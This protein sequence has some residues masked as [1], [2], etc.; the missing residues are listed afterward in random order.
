M[1]TK[2]RFSDTFF[3]RQLMRWNANFN[4]REM[5]WKG[6]SDPY[7]IWLSEIILQQ[8]QVAQG[9]SYYHKFIQTYPTVSHL[10]NADPNDVFKLWEGL[11]YYSRCKNLL[12]AANQIVTNFNCRFPDTYNDILSLKGI[13]PYTAAAIASFAFKLPY[14][15]VDG[16]VIRVLSRYFAISTPYDTTEGKKIFQE[17]ANELLDT[18][19]PHL[20]NQAIMDFGAT[21]CT[22]ANPACIQCILSKH[23]ASNLKNNVLDFPVKSKKI[24]K[25]KRFFIF[26]IIENNK[27]QILVKKREQN[28]IWQNLHQFFEI[29]NESLFLA[30]ND[31]LF[32]TLK[33]QFP[34]LQFS[35]QL[36]VF[37]EQKQTLTHQT[38]YSKFITGVQLNDPEIASGYSW[39]NIAD[40]DKIAFPKTAQKAVKEL[41]FIKKTP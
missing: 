35:D 29:E 23:C 34:G 13:G 41:I 22:P 18:K 30:E 6:E 14:A 21:V 24:L 5:P 11:G 4:F 38:V 9:L 33:T 3:T 20:Y 7:K 1:N 28:D 26:L 17:K 36:T 31:T 32:Q 8:T 2:E 39:I 37:D 19:Q 25:R 10:N 27:K 15:V 40:L 16:N 12:F